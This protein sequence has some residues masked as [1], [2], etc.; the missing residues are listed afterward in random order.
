VGFMGLL[1]IWEDGVKMAC[2]WGIFGDGG[3]IVNNLTMF[4]ESWRN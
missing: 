3:Y 2:L 1:H 4:G